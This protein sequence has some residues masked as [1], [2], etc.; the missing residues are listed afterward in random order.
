MKVALLLWVLG[1]GTLTAQN[2]IAQKA[3]EQMTNG[4][5]AQAVE[6]W[7]RA[8]AME[9]TNDLYYFKRGC[10]YLKCNRV[11]SA[12]LDFAKAVEYEPENAEYS[13]HQGVAYFEQGDF[14]NAKWALDNAIKHDPQ[15]AE[16]LIYK[17][18]TLAAL[19]QNRTAIDECR[20]ILRL[21]SDNPN[22][23]ILVQRALLY[24]KQGDHAL[25][26]H[27]I[28]QAQQ[29]TFES[30][31]YLASLGLYFKNKKDYAQAIKAYSQAY[32]LDKTNP[33]YV[34]ESAYLLLQIGDHKGCYEK[35]T[36]LMQFANARQNF[37]TG[38]ILRAISGKLLNLKNE[39]GY[40]IDGAINDFNGNVRKEPEYVFAAG[41]FAEYLSED[42][43][44][45]KQ[46]KE[47]ITKA[48]PDSPS[49]N[50]LL[51]DIYFK[52]DETT[53]AEEVAKKTAEMLRKLKGF[54][55]EKKQVADLL[56]NI[57]ARSA[58]RTPPVIQIIS[59]VAMRGGVIVEEVNEIIVTGLVNDESGIK[60][61]LI[62]GNPARIEAEGR[63]EG[64]TALV[65]ENT[66]IIV[67]AFDK[68]GNEG[69]T[70]III[71]KKKPE[72][73]IY[74]IEEAVAK[75]LATGGKNYAILFANNEYQNWSSLYNPINDARTLAK[76]LQN[77]YGFETEIIENCTQE[78]FILK[79]RQYIQK[80]F[81]DRDQLLIFYAGHGHFDDTFNVGG[82][83]MTDSEAKKNSLTMKSYISYDDLRS[84]ISAIPCKHTL[85][86][87]DACFSGTIDEEIAK[88]RGDLDFSNLL[89]AQ[90]LIN[91]LMSYTTRRYITSGGKEYV[92]DGKPGGHS[93]FMRK[94]LEAMRSRGGED[95]VLTV[96][97]IGEYLREVPKQFPRPCVGELNSN[98]T[99][100]DFLFIP[101]QQ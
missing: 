87:A 41:V 66:R 21:T 20:K 83:V 72:T 86:I 78:Q 1:V 97:E 77:I 71:E 101:K 31:R 35:S 94:L 14:T 96:E 63:F 19:D 58:D 98:E 11:N 62:N 40:I 76:E 53:L 16:Y 26:E 30:A 51:A 9:A 2:N 5:Y 49:N 100:S 73:K 28:E 90:N 18:K 57:A 47:W 56:A 70:N 52:L 84:Y 79:I 80:K 85:Y 93:P 92:P 34:Y 81:T 64:K 82:L 42:I 74:K 68:R 13:F 15:N 3:T 25:A 89:S 4:A 7:S 50:L 91:R 39:L 75:T 65:G 88:R 32:Q 54:E 24:Q 45:L 37:S 36:K 69:S 8:I 38:F 29:N 95:K 44:A 61:V 59:P 67:Q 17:I 55:T 22:P 43:E 99:S 6:T 23:E 60:K 10:C 12:L 46:A 33:H 48:S 27:D